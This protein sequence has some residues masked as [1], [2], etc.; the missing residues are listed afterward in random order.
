MKNIL[1]STGGSGGHVVPAKILCEH[2]QSNFNVFIS[3]DLRGLKYLN[4]KKDDVILINTPKLNLNIFFI[5]KIFQVIYLVIKTV[6]LMKKNKITIVFSTGGYMSL[7]VC[8]G[9]KFLGVKIY[10]FEPNIVLGRANKLFLHFCNK[11]FSYT[12]NLKNFPEKLKNKIQIITPLVKKNF[13]EKRNAKTEN[14]VFCLLVV[15]GSQGA[16]IFDEIVKDVILNYSKKNKI[17][18]IHQTNKSNID[19]LKNIYDEAEVENIIFDF[20]E[21]LADL[22]NQSDLCITRAGASTLAELSMMN[23][24]FLTVP[25]VSAKDNHQYENANFYKNLGCCWIMSQKD[26][27][28][29]NL[30]KF[31]DH[32][33][34]NKFEY[35]L[36]KNNLEKHNFQNSWNNINKKILDTVNEN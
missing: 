16:K 10:L 17:K 20:E 15:G 6:L 35:N 3:T 8:L 14:K 31:L 1:I 23:K 26:F 5:F 4:D 21:N 24:P 28:V 19:N 9:A 25:L 13:Y 32:V 33:I 27:N 18:I 11:I 12:R 34:M 22:I 29:V 2:L 36:K 7:P 30:E